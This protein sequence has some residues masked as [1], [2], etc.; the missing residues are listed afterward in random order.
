MT[1]TKWPPR[2]PGRFSRVAVS[3]AN[4]TI[5]PH[6]TRHASNDI[7]RLVK[8]PSDVRDMHSHQIDKT[9]RRVAVSAAN[10]TIP[11]HPTRHASNDISHLVRRPI[12][13]RDMHSHQIDKTQRRVAVS[14]ANPTIP[15][16][17]TRHASNDISHLCEA[18]DRC[19]LLAMVGFAARRALWW[20]SLRSPPPY[21]SP[22]YALPK[23]NLT[24]FFCHV[25]LAC[26][27]RDG[28]AAEAGSTITTHRTFR[29]SACKKSMASDRCRRRCFRIGE[30]R[31]ALRVAG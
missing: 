7:S 24:P 27:C 9:E 12:D 2:F 21:G 28:G 11:P 26:C 22:P 15:P 3:A 5:P 20:G 30:S 29:H 31:L 25:A 8:R 18:A 6:P 16:H 14:A 1:Q 13:V 19:V 10:P 17:P 4:P 23:M